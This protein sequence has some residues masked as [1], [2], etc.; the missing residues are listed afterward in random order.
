[1]TTGADWRRLAHQYTLQ[2]P[3]FAP[4]APVASVPFIGTDQ[5]DWRSGLHSTTPRLLHAGHPSSSIFRAEKVLHERCRRS[6]HATCRN[7]V[8]K[9]LQNL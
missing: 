8:L 9:T 2:S 1:M 4:V 3:T 6:I 7:P 5:L